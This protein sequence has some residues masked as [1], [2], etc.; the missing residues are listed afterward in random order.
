MMV[1]KKQKK[2]T[3]NAQEK[4]GRKTMQNAKAGTCA[5]FERGCA[6]GCMQL[7][8]KPVQFFSSSVPLSLSATPAPFVRSNVAV[9]LTLAS[10]IEMVFYSLY[11]SC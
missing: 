10:T 3:H 4:N 7:K 6:F 8:L 11:I 9:S 1:L 5:M 2:N